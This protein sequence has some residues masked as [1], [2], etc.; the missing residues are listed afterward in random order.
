MKL[1]LNMPIVDF[2]EYIKTHQILSNPEIKKLIESL[3]ENI[4]KNIVSYI[5]EVA[6]FEMVDT[7]K[8]VFNVTENTHQNMPLHEAISLARAL[9][10]KRE[11]ESKKV[12]ANKPVV[13]KERAVVID[14]PVVN[15]VDSIGL[16]TVNLFPIDQAEK[17]QPLILASL[18]LNKNQLDSL[19]LILNEP[20][21]IESGFNSIQSDSIHDAI[22][23]LTSRSRKNKTYY[24]SEELID[25]VNNFAEHHTIKPS[26][27][28]EV[29]IIEVLKKYDK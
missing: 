15:E 9:R 2:Y 27:L 21:S 23:K 25:K 29:A 26:A 12:A 3:N 5:F 8:K 13:K 10:L 14:K 28:I 24:I 6:E 7:R 18:G 4:S 11:N 20:N 19:K 17:L 22:R 16:N 1:S